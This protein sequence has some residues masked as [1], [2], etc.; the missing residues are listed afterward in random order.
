MEKTGELELLKMNMWYYDH[1][2]LILVLGPI[3]GLLLLGF[4]VS[5]QSEEVILSSPQGVRHFLGNL[6]RVLIRVFGYVAG[7][8]AVQHL[9]GFP[10]GLAW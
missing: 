4:V 7:L 8:L 10:I 3:L 5:V 6:S 1:L 2:R 9:I